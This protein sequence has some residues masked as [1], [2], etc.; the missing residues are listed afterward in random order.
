MANSVPTLTNENWHMFEPSPIETSLAANVDNPAT[1]SAR[2][3][4]FRYQTQSQLSGQRYQDQ[5][6]QMHAAQIAQ[7]MMAQQTAR[8]GQMS[9]SLKDATSAPG[10]TDVYRQ[11]G[12]L[13]QGVDTSGFDAGTQAAAS[14]KNMGEAGRGIGSAAMGG[15]TGLAPAAQSVFGPGTDQGPSAL[16]KAAG[17]RAAASGGNN[18]LAT[19]STPVG[20]PGPNQPTVRMKLHPSLIP[21]LPPW[22]ANG[23][24][25]PP[26][27]DGISNNPLLGNIPG[28]VPPPAIGSSTDAAT[29]IRND[30]ASSKIPPQHQ[31]DGS[32]LY[33]GAS[34]KKYIKRG[35]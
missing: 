30:I 6:D 1:P 4:L 17:I 24:S 28:T 5:I 25:E 15:I 21:G 34:G 29:T 32:T 23:S 20:P 13:P 18:G 22:M 14:S 3:N 10:M 27:S 2:G 16:E 35:S 26:S 12:I 33:I 8:N 31:S 19:I 9:T 11:L 7:A